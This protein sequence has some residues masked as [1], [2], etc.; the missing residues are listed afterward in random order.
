MARENLNDLSAFVAVAEAHSFTKAAARLGISP[1][2]LS[3]AM[4][5]LE[6][7]LGVRLL[8]RTTRSVAPTEAGER[9]L[10]VVLP[11]LQGIES[12]LSALN[13]LRD[14]PAGTIRLTASEHA[15]YTVIYPVLARLAADYP[16]IKI[17]V[18]VDNMLADLVAGR[19]DAGIRLGE[20]VERDMVAVRIAPDMRMAI[21]GTPAYFERHPRPETP[22]DLTQ[23]DCI[24]IRLP[25]HGGLLPWEFDKDGR[26]ITVRVEGQLIFNT[27]NLALRAVLDGLG[28]GYCLD[29]MA[30]EAIADGRLIRVLEDW[31]EPFPGY[32]IYYPSRRQLSPA[33]RLL[34]DALRFR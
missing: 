22:Q 30:A 8:A 5:G 27:N 29:D 23:H 12:E 11:H 2:A 25:T 24:G 9:L 15:A 6:E 3:H 1:S 14:I 33:L 34:I 16:E 31:C 18:N 26:S 28:L 21:V 19:F 4:R 20:H 13:L 10:T 17:E 32:H 7:R